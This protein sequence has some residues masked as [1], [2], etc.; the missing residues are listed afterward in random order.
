MVV[1]RRKSFWA[2]RR[3]AIQSLWLRL[4]SGLRQSGSTLLR[5]AFAARLNRGGKMMIAAYGKKARG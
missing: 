5:A 2:G 1:A 3:K 4:H